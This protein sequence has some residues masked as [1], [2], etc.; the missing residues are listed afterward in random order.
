MNHNKLYQQYEIQTGFFYEHFSKTHEQFGEEDIHQLRV[1]IKKIRAILGLVEYISEGSFSRERHISLFSK[2]FKIS[3]RLREIHVNLSIIN[4][5][6]QSTVIVY[7]EYLI[8]L[9]LK[10]VQR[11]N[12][13]LSSFNHDELQK[14]NLELYE[15]IEGLNDLNIADM[16]R[17]YISGKIININELRKNTNDRN[18]HK[19][20][21]HSKELKEILKLINSIN[22]DDQSKKLENDIKNFNE[23]IG[24]WHDN[25][26]LINSMEKFINKENESLEQDKLIELVEDIKQ[27]NLERKANVKVELNRII[28]SN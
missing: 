9:Q 14:L 4:E 24:N 18:L 27:K 17:S 26:V 28:N 20:R 2:L 16:A 21:F 13:G 1:D 23:L 3:G 6:D 5:D 11:L 19:I 12:T 7:R 15:F 22:P 25:V 10:T 8:I